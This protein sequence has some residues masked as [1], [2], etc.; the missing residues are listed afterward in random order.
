MTA[1][2]MKLV[3]PLKIAGARA[4]IC[5]LFIRNLILS[6][7]IGVHGHERDNAQRVRLNLDL[8][9]REDSKPLGD[10]IANVVCYEKIA[11]EA[12]LITGAGHFNLVET[13]AEDIAAMCLK[14][15]RVR[16]ARVRVEKMDVF[17][18]AGGAGVEIER[19]N[20]KG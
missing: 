7:S 3:E 16:S 5:H 4:G 19:F 12:R 15:S 11:A 1:S 2:R 8:A 9:V 13:L 20:P 14:D 10:E 18:D 17:S 6:C